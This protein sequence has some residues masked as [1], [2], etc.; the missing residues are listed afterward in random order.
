MKKILTLIFLLFHFSS[1]AV[2]FTV[3]HAPG[4]VSDIVTRYLAKEMQDR[5][6]VIINRPGAS[7]KVAL[8][9]MMNEKTMMLAT[10]VQVFATN[11]INFKDLGHDP[12]KDIENLAIIGI[13]PSALVCN[14]KTG[15]NSFE[16]FK[17]IDKSLSFGVSLLGS[18]EHLATEIF[19]SKF[20]NNHIII[21]YSQGGISGVRDLLG[22]HIDC[23]FINYPTIK[24][25]LK[26]DS[27]KMLLTSHNIEK[28][29]PNWNDIYKEPFPFQS[30]L[31]VIVPK[32]MEKD[33]KDKITRNLISVFNRQEFNE[34]LINLGLF[35][36]AS[37]DSKLINESLLHM[38][39]IQNFIINKKI[40]I[41]S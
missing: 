4:G 8:N 2:E 31:S 30:Y 14:N 40:K 27:I 5:S 24:S 22:G 29:I 36:L 15:I 41:S 38:R 13:M 39:F 33:N 11:P 17:K 21:P 12:Y 16:E 6:Y 26:N 37:T 18:S 23:M 19:L 35:P 3:M 10:M 1:F 32:S 28:S 20:Q 7:G 9:H 34:G 25:H